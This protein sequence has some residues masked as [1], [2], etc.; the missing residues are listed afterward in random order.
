MSAEP[1][2]TISLFFYADWCKPCKRVKPIY[3][4]KIKPTFLLNGVTTYEYNYDTSGTK[5]LMSYY[6]ISTVPTLCVIDLKK[7][8]L[9]HKKLLKQDVIRQTNLDSKTIPTDAL[10][11]LW[12]FNLEEDF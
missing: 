11:L 1:V 3:N 7:A 4:T 2:D 8:G 5:D 10:D 6:G 12:S 9:D